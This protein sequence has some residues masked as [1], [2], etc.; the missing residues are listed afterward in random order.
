M[1]KKAI[2][3]ALF[4]VIVKCAYAHNEKDS[5]QFRSGVALKT[6]L[7]YDLTGTLNLGAEFRLNKKWTL[8]IPFNYNPWNYSDG[9]KLKHWLVQPE[10]RYWNKQA[11]KGSFW[12]VHVHAGL[13]NVARI[14]SNNRQ[15]E[16]WL[17]GAGIAYGYRRNFSNH[18]AIEASIGVGYAY[19]DYDR[20]KL[21][22]EHCCGELV[23]SEHK[24]YLGVTKAAVSL[25]Y[26]IGKKT[27]VSAPQ[28]EPIVD[29]LP[30]MPPRTDTVRVVQTDTVYV[31][32]TPVVRYRQETGRAYVL[33]PVNR[34]VLNP[35]HGQNRMELAT[36]GRSMQAIRQHADAEIKSIHIESFASPEGDAEHNALLAEQR[37]AALRDYMVETHALS[38]ALF[39]TCSGGENWEGLREAIAATQ[40][41]T[42]A[43]KRDLEQILAIGDV[44]QRKAQ[45][46]AYKRGTVYTRLLKEIYP[47]LRIST[48]RI[49]Y[50][51]PYEELLTN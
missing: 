34:S 2:T 1:I 4:V 44:A 19:I 49:D 50:T 40:Q 27:K 22:D 45:L 16:G 30:Y 9:K 15:Y 48:Y 5:L 47:S 39:T 43:E 13:F 10:W 42:H 28:P 24:H 23:A 14:F 25:I 46:K 8:D 7:L 36:I 38:P 41:L 35:D 32:P 33:F 31:A 6:N 37:A 3:L 12:G 26:N 21:N 11:F 18:W 20:Y 29:L 17:A 51:L